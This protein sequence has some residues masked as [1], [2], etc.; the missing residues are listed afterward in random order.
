MAFRD[1]MVDGTSPRIDNP[2][3]CRAIKKGRSLA[4]PATR[5]EYG[6][7]LGEQAKQGTPMKT[8]RKQSKDKSGRDCVGMC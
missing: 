3:T 8:L 4:T 7:K 6:K 1:L 2:V 5:R